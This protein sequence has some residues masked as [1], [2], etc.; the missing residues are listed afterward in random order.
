[1]IKNLKKDGI[2]KDS[3]Y[4]IFS[5]MYSKFA[6]YLFY[7]LIPFILGTEGFGII[8]GLMPILDTLVIIF[9]S[10]IPPAMAKF[11]SGGDFNEN[12][13]IYD[14][15]KVM[16][17]FSIFGAIFTVFLKYLL[18]G[19]YSNL[20]DVYFYAVAVA[21]PFSVVISWSRGVLQGNLKIKNL[22]KTWILE[23]TSKV[24][25]LV[26]LSY[27]FG[28][29]GGIL[30]ISVS[31]LL[32]GIFGIYLL[33]KSNLE[34]S[35]SNIL[36][37]IFSPIKKSNSVKK[38]IYYSI[39]IALT[40]ASYRLINDL[41]GIFIL[42][43]LG[44]YDNGVYGYASLLSRLLFLF[45][46]A[47]AIVLIPRISKSKDISY[48]KKAT[49]LNISIVLPALL[50]IFLFSK[51][52]LNLFFG[53]STPESIAS[54]KILSI[55]AVFMSTYTI[56]ASSLQGLGYAKIPVY[57]L[58]LGILLN[59]VFNYALIPNLG[60]IGGA[61]ATLSSSFVV[62]VLIWIITFTKLK[63]IKNNS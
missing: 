44:A 33:S 41:D 62:F 13:W 59:A 19:N 48:F 22:S 25:F 15:L 34:Y 29:V 26:I 63:K 2:L 12:T 53:I 16:F 57:I 4:M 7:F 36:K 45:A 60:I 21:L 32:G 37:N 38:V 27:L 50:I 11:I 1:M 8:K 40:T 5:N 17:I 54:L 42:S 3:A 18:G 14:I 24:V 9:C 52:L 23:N 49:I 56:C 43:M 30:S 35:F 51:E 47:I 20:P 39:P 28:V 58:F 10:G 61:I 55:S 6:A 46:S 31:F